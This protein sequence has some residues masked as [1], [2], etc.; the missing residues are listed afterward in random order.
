M[1]EHDAPHAPAHEAEDGPYSTR[2]PPELDPIVRYF[3]RQAHSEH[4]EEEPEGP[5]E[6]P[7]PKEALFHFLHLVPLGRALKDIKTEKP[8]EGVEHASQARD[9]E[10]AIE[11]TKEGDETKTSLKPPPPPAILPPDPFD[12][13]EEVWKQ[14]TVPEANFGNKFYPGQ[15]Q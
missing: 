8:S 11:K 1:A 9:I 10:E 15:E 6:W 3:Q 2:Y 14:R 12:D 7:G 13:L 4:Q 5:K